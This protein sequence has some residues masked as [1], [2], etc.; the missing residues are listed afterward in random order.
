MGSERLPY[1]VANQTKAER[2]LGYIEERADLE[3]R[4]AVVIGGAPA[5]NEPIYPHLGRPRP[6]HA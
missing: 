3:C 5:W 6:C 1:I 4:V 2:G